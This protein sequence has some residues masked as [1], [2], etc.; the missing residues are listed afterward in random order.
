MR[1]LCVISEAYFLCEL[2]RTSAFEFL[3]AM[4]CGAHACLSGYSF[5]WLFIWLQELHQ[6][7]SPTTRT[8]ESI[9]PNMKIKL[10]N[11]GNCSCF[12]ILGTLS[13]DEGDAR[14][15]GLQE[16]TWT[17][18]IPWNFAAVK[19]CSARLL[20]SEL[21][22]AKCAMPELNSKLKNEKLAGAVL[23]VQNT[24]NL[25]ISRCYLQRRAEKCT[26][27]YN[28]R[29]QYVLLILNLLFGGV[30]VAFAIVLRSPYNLFKFSTAPC[31]TPHQFRLTALFPPWRVTRS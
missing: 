5:D 9:C 14:D 15:A 21:T 19:I 18:I 12:R 4:Q 2:F 8:N 11:L 31:V 3:K 6:M 20:L 16:K 7:S 23:V 17:Y 25:V 22:Q 26:K 30:L 1:Q 24:Q 13:N 10:G 29:A 27:I 28:A